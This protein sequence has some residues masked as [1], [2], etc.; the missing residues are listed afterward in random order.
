MKN[1]WKKL[2]E[3]IIAERNPEM[4]NYTKN[5]LAN[6]TGFFKF[7]ADMVQLFLPGMLSAILGVSSSKK[8]K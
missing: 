6:N 3:E 5:S 8:P 1:N 7:I 4:H 2:E